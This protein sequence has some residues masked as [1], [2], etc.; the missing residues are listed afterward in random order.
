MIKSLALWLLFLSNI[1]CA[2]SK[3]NYNIIDLNPT[4]LNN[5]VGKINTQD[6][7]FQQK[8][9]LVV[10][11]NQNIESFLKNTGSEI[12]AYLGDGNYWITTNAN[13]TAML[14]T[15]DYHKIGYLSA[16][17]KIDKQ[18]LEGQKTQ[19]V[20]VM[21]AGGI[22]DDQL[23]AALA[24]TGVSMLSNNKRIHYFTTNATQ[25]Q[26]QQ[27]S[28]L[29]FVSYLTKNLQD[30]KLLMY[31]ALLMTGTN[32]VQEIKPYGYNL[33]GE[34]V[35][36]GIWDDG[37]VGVNIDLPTNKNFVI[38]KEYSSTAY[39]YHPTEVAGC[40]GSE[41]NIFGNLKGMAPR[42]NMYYWDVA[43]DIV[44]EI[45]TGKST[46]SVDI[47]NHSYSFVPT[48]CFQSGMY[49]PEAADLD[50]AVHDNPTLLPVVAVGNT[51]S[52]NCAIA[53]D[54]FSS[55]DIGFQGCKNAITVGWL[56]A[57]ERIV[58]N[59]GRGPTM[60]GRLK[61]E[62]VSKGFAVT[63]DLPNNNL[64]TVYGS[65]YASPQVA[66]IA[67]LLYQKYNQQY[68][69]YPNASLIKSILF[70]TA[71][72]LG[73]TGP[74]YIY[75]FGKPDVYRAVKTVNDNLFYENNS[76]QDAVDTKNI[77]VP[78]NITQLKVTLSWTDK[79]GSPVADKAIVNNLDLKVVTP[80][81]DTIL[82]WK[83]NP[84]NPRIIALRGVDNINNNEQLTLDNPISGNY[85]I[86][87]KGTSVPFGPQN[88]AVSYYFQER[89]VELTFPNGGELIDP[90][91][92]LI[93]W[94]NNGIDSVSRIEFSADS[95]A[96]WQLVVN[97]QPLKLKTY[98]WTIPAVVSNKCLIRI[99]SGN[100]IAVSAAT[101][102]IGT[103]IYYPSI[104]HTV[105]DK[106]VQITWP[107]VAGASAYRVYL[108]ADTAWTLMGETAQTN[109]TICNLT[110]GK[111][112]LYS[113]STIY[114]GIEGNHSLS[115]SF[116]PSVVACNTPT[117]IGVYA[118]FKPAV[119]R[120]FTSLA[121]TATEKMYFN[122]KNFGNTTQNS[123]SV[124]YKI[125]GGAVRTALF[126]KTIAPNDTA[127]VQF[128]VNENLSAT[129]IYNIVA[130]TTL[131]GD[132]N[133]KND[134]LSYKLKHLPNLPLTLP[135]RESFENSYTQ[136]T[137]P[138]FALDGLEYIDY[139]NQIGGRFR[140]DEGNLYARTGKR[141]VT[142]DN[143]LGTGN[144]SNE[145][146]FTYNLANYKD[147]IVFLDFHYMNRSEPDS[148]DVLF[149]RGD[150]T[151]PWVRLYD[152]FANRGDAG[153]YNDVLGMNLYQKLKVENNQQFSSSTQLKILQTGSK[154]AVTPYQYGGYSFDD[155][156]LYVAGNDVAINSVSVKKIHCTKSFI[157]QPVRIKVFNNSGQSIT[158]L[159]VYYQVDNNTLVSENIPTTLAPNDTLTYT[160]N[161]L[162]NKNIAGKYALKAWATNAGDVYHQNDTATAVVIVMNTIDTFPY[163]NAMETDNG[164]L[165]SDGVNNSW[166]WGT[167]S[168]YIMN[169]AAQGNKAWTTGINTGYNFNEDSYL[170]MG[171]MD[172][173]S[174][175]ADPLL[176][177]NFI[178][179]IQTNSDSAFAEYS[180]DGVNWSR[181]GCQNCNLNWYKGNQ[182]SP[183]WDGSILPW[184]VAHTKVALSDLEDVSNFMYRIH[185]MSDDYIVSEGI[186][187]D[188]I[189]V[190]TD[191]KDIATADSTYITQPS[192]GSGWIPF[193]RN[194][195]L[196]AELYDDHK[197]LG[198][199]VLGYKAN[200]DI[201]PTFNNKNLFPRNWVIKPQNKII[202]NYKLR[203][204]V[205]ND[206][207]TH[208]ILN[209]D[210]INRMGDIGMIRYFGLNTNLEIG[211]NHVR[212]YYKYYTPT[213]IHF[214]PFQNGYFVEAETDTLGEFY[215]T[216]T[217]QDQNAIPNISLVN[218]TAQRLNNDVYL[219]WQTTREVNSSYFIIQYSFD[220][221]NF[222]NVDTV[223]AGGFSNKVTQYN[224]LHQ[225]NATS[226][227][228]YY[229]IEMVDNF[230][231]ITYSLIDSVYFAPNTGVKQNTSYATSYIAEDDIVVSLHNKQQIYALVNVFTTT[232]QLQFAKKMLLQNGNN[233]LGIEDFKHWSNGVYVLQIKGTEQNYYSKLIKQ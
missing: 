220:A 56:F 206:E 229:R 199:V 22:D 9:Y 10:H 68:G 144:K 201:E 197:V 49:I 127:T 150:D 37:V 5:P 213:E 35:N 88:Y 65:S 39:M 133:T 233:P 155:F 36:V 161:A 109:F 6:F 159:P 92:A 222:I 101:F 4:M 57:D 138:T 135:M 29:P 60:D 209:E 44:N 99:T 180:V 163:Y 119:G 15:T 17:D 63:A 80:S 223:P 67:A 59:S 45:L 2:F 14:K 106:M 191:Y 97:N 102:T 110:N 117:D 189:R 172:F 40:I 111:N 115:K 8:D 158:N 153:A 130:W 95:G 132:N 170:Y 219:Q 70:N 107:A 142:L 1:V 116:S 156:K 74:D 42:C 214:Y 200:I 79:E 84:N 215:L 227:I 221:I 25:A 75:G 85:T 12:Q 175:T 226:G 24:N 48:T 203:L 113:I 185:M 208:F 16:V 62:L 182:N 71:R 211:D 195:K 20:L 76:T 31:D 81:G 148:N 55:V 178:T 134:T 173:T 212:N 190:F 83:L 224:Y 91:T 77:L 118:M 176:A 168:K 86:V 171:C 131:T 43:G 114:N 192:S 177:F 18:L 210:S 166:A 90:G 3:E 61:P 218:L 104:A 11:P 30:R 32:Q 23:L 64:G 108:F 186:G 98:N 157:A 139:T 147:S 112:Y 194:G 136:L 21:Y 187:V 78:N 46:Y 120:K 146:V 154:T 188:D 47:S 96:T 193:Y 129:G 123:F 230:N 228:Y 160:F 198:N 151:K 231:K 27:L 207:Y 50:K 33:K 143:Y 202:G 167:P 121:L 100:N 169:D 181:L 217:K 225:L 128:N 28:K 72:D 140:T 93:R 53:T 125:N 183:C 41:G 13:Q 152:L 174:L 124:S 122:I 141:A 137:S 69:I 216:S 19:T 89:K 204:Y 82:P 66:G 73:P 54:T 51:A 87:V 126:T 196:V 232:G 162:F 149:V 26:L 205:L 105:C 34:G 184:Q 38:D 94:N 103:Q 7:R 164:T 165:F 179:D 145:V 52:A 58:E